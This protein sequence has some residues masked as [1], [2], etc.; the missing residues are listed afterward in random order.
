M[1]K[2]RAN[3]LTDKIFDNILFLAEVF[4]EQADSDIPKMPVLEM[5]KCF[6]LQVPRVH[7][8]HRSRAWPLWK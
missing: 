1:T 7:H 6:D 8:R 2:V 4:G 3:N 5:A